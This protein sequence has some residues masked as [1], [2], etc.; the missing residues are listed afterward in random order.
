MK[1]RPRLNSVAVVLTVEVAAEEM[2]WAC[3]V[4]VV[5]FEMQVD[6][7]AAVV[8]VEPL[9]QHVTDVWNRVGRWF[10]AVAVLGL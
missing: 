6:V 3:A 9:Q 10:E 8:G 2:S 1:L 5:V 4:A 7:D